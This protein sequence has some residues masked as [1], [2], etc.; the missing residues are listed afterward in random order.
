MRYA[1]ETNVQRLLM[2]SILFE[3]FVEPQDL[4]VEQMADLH[5]N[6]SNFPFLIS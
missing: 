2:L 3:K 6:S 1:L 4:F 5:S